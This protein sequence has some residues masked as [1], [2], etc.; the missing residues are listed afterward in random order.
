MPRDCFVA[1]VTETGDGHDFLR[2]AME[3]GASCAVVSKADHSIS[4]PQFV[5]E[6]TSA[7]LEKFAR[8]ARAKFC[9]T[10]IAITGSFGKTTTK[11]IL[12]LLLGVKNNA[13]FENKNGK[14]GIPMTLAAL[15]DSENFAIIEVGIDAPGTVD[16]Y[17]DMIM[18][19]IAIVTGIGKIHIGGMVSEEAIACE[20]C[21]LP[22]YAVK[23][24]GFGIL[25][26]ECARF[27]CFR[28][29]GNGC[30]GISRG[31]K[32][33][34]YEIDDVGGQYNITLAFDGQSFKFA[35]PNSMS[36]GTAKNFILACV[37]AM[38]LG[39]SVELVRER[40][41]QWRPAKWRGEIIVS[42]NKTYFADCYNAN[43]IA[44]ADSLEH[45]DRLFPNCG[46]MFVI[47]AL[48]TSEIGASVDDENEKIFQNLP[49][50]N[51][52]TVVIVGENSPRL[53]KNIKSNDVIAVQTTAN[54]M[55]YVK[56]FSGVVYLKG[57]RS[58]ELEK[59]L[60]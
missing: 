55:K 5:C 47:G 32:E 24:G 9:G 4:L 51:N 26:E 20:K 58:Y 36:R 14:I 53:R 44:M 6:D 56:N 29:L 59:L 3:K 22:A 35:L 16:G 54:A 2:N 48:K 37:C 27:E 46:R 15:V 25:A 30:I 41:L 28:T 19:N 13:T 18:P 40:I 34:G 60:P 31:G 43:P 1:F 7:A 50:R 10:T 17:I 33:H 21:K 8:F 52:D 12:K 11:E 38:K 39:V 45:F 57:H 49:I 23:N 42:G